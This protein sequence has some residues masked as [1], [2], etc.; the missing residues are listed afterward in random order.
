MRFALTACSVALLSA[1]ALAELSLGR[2]DVEDFCAESGRAAPPSAGVQFD[3]ASADERIMTMAAGRYDLP[4][5]AAVLLFESGAFIVRVKD[6]AEQTFGSDGDDMMARGG[7][8]GGCSREQLSEVLAKNG[9][10]A[11]LL[12]Q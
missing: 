9:L 5:N 3:G 10:D 11:G 4:E 8:V 6:Y 12:R 7:L 1:S 2:G